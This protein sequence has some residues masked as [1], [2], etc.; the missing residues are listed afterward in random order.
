[1]KINGHDV[2]DILNYF[3]AAALVVAL[4]VLVFCGSLWLIAHTIKSL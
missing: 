4:T 1:M 2:G 3:A